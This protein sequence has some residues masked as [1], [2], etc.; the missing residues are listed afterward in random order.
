MD[1]GFEKGEGAEGL[2][3]RP[4]GQGLLASLGDFLKNWIRAWCTGL[5]DKHLGRGG[6]AFQIL[7]IVISYVPDYFYAASIKPS[8]LSKKPIKR[9]SIFLVHGSL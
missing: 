7:T 2:E 3:D 8:K 6:G 9:A 4:Q 5:V 1:P